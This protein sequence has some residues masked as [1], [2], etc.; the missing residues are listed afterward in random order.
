MLGALTALALAVAERSDATRSALK[1]SNMT[2]TGK[3]VGAVLV[4]AIALSQRGSLN[5]VLPKTSPEKTLE[6]GRWA[7]VWSSVIERG[8]GARWGGYF[9]QEL[10]GYRRNKTKGKLK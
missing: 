9:G 1:S 8:V 10:Y 2:L 6:K 3:E 7:G 5:F 4:D